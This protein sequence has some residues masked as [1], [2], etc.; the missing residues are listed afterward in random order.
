MKI[1]PFTYNTVST[2]NQVHAIG[3]VWAT[4]FYEVYWNLVDSHGFAV[5]L[6][7]ATQKKGNVTFLQNMLGGM[8]IQPCS[9]KFISARDAIISADSTYYGGINKCAI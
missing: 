7:G 4:I 1:N 8:K 6:L 9:P 3:S 2:F 5:D